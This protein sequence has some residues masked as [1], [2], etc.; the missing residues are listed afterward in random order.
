V[1]PYLISVFKND[2]AKLAAALRA[3][4]LI[5]SGST[6]IQV[7]DADAKQLAEANPK[8]KLVTVDGMN[9]VLKSVKQTHRLLQLP[10][11]SDPSLPLHPELMPALVTFLKVSLSGK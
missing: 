1:Q 2:P 7:S 9:H 3:P 6:D 8:A 5:V 10:S 11:Y 4:L